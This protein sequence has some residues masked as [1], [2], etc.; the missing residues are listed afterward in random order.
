MA[1]TLRNAPEHLTPLLAALREHP[2]R[3]SLFAALRLL[4]RLCAEQPR[5]GESPQ[6][7]EALVRFAQR[8]C[9]AFEPAEIGAFDERLEQRARLEEYA[10]GLFGPNGALP[11]DSAEFAL[12]RR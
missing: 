2:R 5:S 10:F 8:S 6:V 1:D 11:L 9:L 12:E 7:S 3:F 4:E